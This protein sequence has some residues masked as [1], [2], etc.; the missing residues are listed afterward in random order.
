MDYHFLPVG[1]TNCSTPFCVFRT[2]NIHV[3]LLVVIHVYPP[4]VV[5]HVYPPLVVIH[6]YQQL[7]LSDR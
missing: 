7:H 2:R 1:S 6:V 5:V 3:H 4:F